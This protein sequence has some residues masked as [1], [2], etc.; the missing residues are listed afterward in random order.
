MSKRKRDSPREHHDEEHMVVCA[1]DDDAQHTGG[2]LTR[3]K[4]LTALEVWKRQPSRLTLQAL[5]RNAEMQAVILLAREL[6]VAN[7]KGF[8]LVLEE[9]IP[10]VTRDNALAHQAKFILQIEDSVHSAITLWGWNDKFARF[11]N[12]LDFAFH[13]SRPYPHTKSHA[14]EANKDVIL[15]VASVLPP[16]DALEYL[17]AHGYW[18]WA[19]MLDLKAVVLHK[20]GNNEYRKVAKSAMKACAD[21][22]TVPSAELITIFMEAWGPS[23]IPFLDRICVN[24]WWDPQAFFVLL[25]HPINSKVAE[26]RAIQL[27]NICGGHEKALSLA[28]QHTSLAVSKRCDL[29]FTFLQQNWDSKGPLAVLQARAVLLALLGPG[30]EDTALE[31]FANG[32][33]QMLLEEDDD[34][35]RDAGLLFPPKLSMPKIKGT[36]TLAAKSWTCDVETDAFLSLFP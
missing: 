5:Y 4:G 20:S 13:G 17:D 16:E 36:F 33:V 23:A 11:Y 14:P 19:E 9:I 30:G 31:K 1:D 6:G 3:S 25:K 8:F 26:Q 10:M 12:A 7:E 15:R 34:A 29:I 18:R 28:L 24:V 32:A 22:K 21:M 27:L 2:S 35:A